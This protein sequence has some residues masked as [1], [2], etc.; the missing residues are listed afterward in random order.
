M[1]F[2]ISGQF[3][4]PQVIGLD[5]QRRGVDH[6]PH[7]P[8][9]HEDT[10][11]QDVCERLITL[12]GCGHK[13]CA[14]IVLAVER[15]FSLREP[16]SGYPV[17]MRTWVIALA[18]LASLPAWGDTQFRIRQMTRDDVPRGKGQCDIRLQVDNEVEIS[19]RGDMVYSRT[20]AG[21]EPR[22]DG[23]E[24]NTPLPRREI[25]ALQFQVVDSRNDIRMVAPPDRRNDFAAVVHIRDSSGGFGRYHFRLSWDMN[26][27]GNT[28]PPDIRHDDDRRDDDRRVPGFVW[29]NVINFRGQ[30]RGAAVSSTTPIHGGSPTSTSISTAAAESWSPSGLNAGVRWY[31]PGS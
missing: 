22:D 5:R 7:G 2:R 12:L 14:F 8:I 24:C 25:P 10:L 31:S 11:R 26:A 13:R 1:T 16:W 4:A 18:V 27:A 19:V 6:R 28:R 20:L 23:S 29:N 9:D 3:S 15:P 30:G 17:H 21:Q